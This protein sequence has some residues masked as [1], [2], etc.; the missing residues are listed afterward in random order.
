[1]KIL[2]F[3]PRFGLLLFLLFPLPARSQSLSLGL[4][5]AALDGILNA[6]Y[7]RDHKLNSVFSLEGLKVSRITLYAVTVSFDLVFSGEM[8]V[9][10][11]F[12]KVRRMKLSRRIPLEASFVPRFSG[13]SLEIP[14]K[15]ITLSFQ[16]AVHMNVGSNPITSI[17]ESFRRWMGSDS[18]VDLLQKK[19]TLD[20]SPQLFLWFGNRKFTGKVQL[21]RDR[22]LISLNPA[23]P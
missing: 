4:D 18:A 13:H 5:A 15:E 23:S 21:S 22:I 16:D 14:V 1:M 20:L 10:L 6:E 17:V 2:D 11:P 9:R 7:G 8:E 19:L 12:S 3:F